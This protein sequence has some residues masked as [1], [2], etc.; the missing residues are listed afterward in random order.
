[1]V[2]C[3]YCGRE[4]EDEDRMVMKEINVGF[5]ELQNTREAFHT[6]CFKKWKREKIMTMAKQVTVTSTALMLFLYVVLV[7][8]PRMV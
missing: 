1:M 4:T 3:Y 2:S 8:I 5:L 7:V 6:E